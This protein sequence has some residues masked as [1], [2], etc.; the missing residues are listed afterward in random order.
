[1][2][3]WSTAFLTTVMSQCKNWTKA[4]STYNV[5]NVARCATTCSYCWRTSKMSTE[6]KNY[7]RLGCKT[8]ASLWCSTH[9]Y[10]TPNITFKLWWNKYSVV[11]G[12]RKPSTI[13]L[14]I[15]F[16]SC[17]QLHFIEYCKMYSTYPDTKLDVTTRHNSRQTSQHHLVL[18][19]YFT[20]NSTDEVTPCSKV[21][22]VMIV[23]LS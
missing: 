7:C 19:T 23:K 3:W 16:I 4:K 5:L 6:T 11:L 17:S 20:N 12:T 1:M 13:N 21:S 10:S 8:V 9:N 2:K 22:T 14:N 15:C 18:L